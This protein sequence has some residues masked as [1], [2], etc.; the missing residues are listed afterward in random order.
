M[1][2]D[3][4][5]VYSSPMGGNT[6][7]Q[8]FPMETGVTFGKGDMVKLDTDGQVTECVTEETFNDILGVAMAGPNGPGGVTLNNPRRTGTSTAYADGDRFP[9]AIPVPGQLFKTSN[10]SAGGTAFDD[11]VP[12]ATTI[13]ALCSLA[14]IAGVW[15]LDEGP[16]AG[17]EVARVVDVLDARGDS[18]ADNG[19]TLTLQS[20]GGGY[21]LVFTIQ[22]GQLTDTV[23]DIT[24]EN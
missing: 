24:V 2:Y 15:G 19:A 17:S 12:S 9:V 21:S 6:W 4:I 8:H 20:A 16:T 10:W 14:L 23:A 5:K 1:A 11:V 13:G 7:I 18:V 22:G 3:D